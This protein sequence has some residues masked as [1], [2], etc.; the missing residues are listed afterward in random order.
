MRKS[1]TLISLSASKRWRISIETTQILKTLNRFL[2][3]CRP[4]SF[5]KPGISLFLIVPD[6]KIV[7]KSLRGEALKAKLKE[8]LSN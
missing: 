8:N 4:C 6:G 3:R 7:A 2:I 5:N 1:G